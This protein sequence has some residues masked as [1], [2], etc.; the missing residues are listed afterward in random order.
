M[1][2]IDLLT[3]ILEGGIRNTN[4][5]NGRIL[6]AEDL[7]AEQ[8]ATR[9]HRQRLG[10]AIGPGIV[11]GLEVA[12]DPATS[13]AARPVLSVGQGM[14]I[15]HKGQILNLKACVKVALVDVKQVAFAGAGLFVDCST[16]T[17][18]TIVTGT[19]AHLLVLEPVSA[20]EGDVPLPLTAGNGRQS[21]CGSRFAVEGAR[22]NLV[23]IREFPAELQDNSANA[24]TTLRNRLAHYCFGSHRMSNRPRDPLAADPQASALDVMRAAGE[25]TPCQVPLALVLWGETN[26]A[27]IDMWAVRRLI[28]TDVDPIFPG[29]DLVWATMQQFQAQLAEFSKLE[30]V[31]ALSHFFFL[32]PVGR[33][34]ISAQGLELPIFAR[35]NL[36]LTPDFAARF[37]ISDAAIVAPFKPA[38]VNGVNLTEFFAN[39]FDRLPNVI[40]RE[41]LWRLFRLALQYP[42]RKLADIDE[43]EVYFV[44][45]E[46]QAAQGNPLAAPVAYFTFAD[47]ARQ[48]CSRARFITSQGTLDLDAF[49]AT[50]VNT[51]DTYECVRQVFLT[52]VVN[53]VEFPLTA[54]DMAGLH[55]IDQI[56]S[57]ANG[58][59]TEAISGCLSNEALWQDF[60][61]LA[62]QEKNFVDVWLETVLRQDQGGRYPDELQAAI[63]RIRPLVI[64]PPISGSPGII[65][66]LQAK[67]LVNA[68]R[69]QREVNEI[70]HRDI[71]SALTARLYG[72]VRNDRGQ[73]LTGA[74]VRVFDQ[75]G[76][77]VAQTQ[78]N[79]VSEGANYEISDLSVGVYI[80]NVSLAGHRS[81]SRSVR[82]SNLDSIRQDFIL[83]V[84]APAVISG[85]VTFRSLFGITQP[86]ANAEVR[87]AG[88]GVSME[89]R[90]DGK[91]AYGLTVS[92]DK[93]NGQSA[94]LIVTPPPIGFIFDRTPK[95]RIF[96]LTSGS[97]KFNF[98]FR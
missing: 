20:F 39:K 27:F 95:V 54:E 26:L 69:K 55:V 80:V 62:A 34:P 64:N 49:T 9:E 5:F 94:N 4:F 87:L 23:P 47:V 43:I 2:A 66:F 22:F 50:L 86:L 15:N 28:R 29:T 11:S 51:T 82:I 91:G 14:A 3:P 21:G 59:L 32:P 65:G 60:S 72:L 16:A 38:N 79:G 33:L 81:E 35:R 92:P 89:T 48:F 78:T 40:E 18:E 45:D 7:Q 63:E 88:K 12:L 17:E 57:I 13:T 36:N 52:K 77:L 75:A 96:Q 93:V 61:R 1:S 24:A 76:A 37:N 30:Q 8:A 83:V 42:P 31:T 71:C 90:T 85:I 68:E 19:G 67:D 44:A 98:E 84:Q 6:S 58:M 73:P 10:Q 97:H 41:E 46:L 53:R 25:L 74:D 70:L 56:L